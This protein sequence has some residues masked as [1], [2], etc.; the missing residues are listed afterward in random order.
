MEAG[1]AVLKISCKNRRRKKRLTTLAGCLNGVCLERC[2][3]PC[4][5]QSRTDKLDRRT[6]TAAVEAATATCNISSAADTDAACDS[7]GVVMSEEKTEGRQDLTEDRGHVL[8]SN[9]ME[10]NAN[11]KRQLLANFIRTHARTHTHTH[12]SKH[13][14]YNYNGK[15]SSNDEAMGCAGRAVHAGQSL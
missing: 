7:E 11:D 12:R 10:T 2:S 4:P 8:T 15:Y 3:Q 1:C 9:T 14:R 6:Q 5:V 13:V